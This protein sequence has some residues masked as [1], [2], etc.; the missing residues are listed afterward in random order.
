M[1][2]HS[3]PLLLL[4]VNLVGAAGAAPLE[5]E[6]KIPLGE[7]RGRIDHLAVDLKRHRLYVAELGNDS[8]GVV[9]LQERRT[10][11]TLA[12]LKEPQGIG[13]VASTDTLY[14][15][16]AGDGSVRLFQGETLSEIARVALGDDADNVRVDE[17]AQRV[18]V[19]YGNGAL[20]VIDTVNQ[21]K[22]A[23]IPLRAHPESFQL[24]H[25]SSRVFVNIPDAGEVAAVD[26]AI[27]Q[28]VAS[29]PTKDLRANFAL[30]LDEPHQRVVTVFRH[31]ARVAVFRTE[32][33]QLLATANTCDDADDVFIDEKRNRIYVSCGEGFIDVL[34]AQG[35]RVAS[36]G[37]IPTV[38]GART[39]H[40][41]PSMDRFV[42][43]VRS[44]GTTPAA[45]WVFRP[46]S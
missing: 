30:A 15:A 11:R 14:V 43:A 25:S 10:L 12:G 31:P 39:G 44:T 40:F 22:I 42:L 26:R 6:A 46:A 24:D 13:Y 2:A 29:W 45:I 4:G 41:I 38:S 9:D 33:G 17:V 27:N 21:R 7:V 23:D 1:R 36:I 34:A 16:N 5:L 19:G 37:R 28:Q 35:D 3:L 8:I 20:A 18:Y 32:D